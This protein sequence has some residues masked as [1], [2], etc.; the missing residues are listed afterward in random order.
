MENAANALKIAGGV[1]LGI[2]V[3]GAL[4]LMVNQVSDYEKSKRR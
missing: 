4:I 2:M 1:L 3:L